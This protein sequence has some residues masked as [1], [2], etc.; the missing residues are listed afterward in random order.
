MERDGRR[1][2]SLGEAALK[3][4]WAR[5]ILGLPTGTPQLSLLPRA[6]APVHR[7]SYAEH[8]VWEGNRF[9]TVPGGPWSS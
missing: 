8:V 6:R 1:G 4:N 9:Q 3:S 2:L 5:L 7:M